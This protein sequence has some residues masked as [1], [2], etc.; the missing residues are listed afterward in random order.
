MINACTDSHWGGWGDP[1]VTFFRVFVLL[2]DVFE[3]GR[4]VSL[5]AWLQCMTAVALVRRVSRKSA[6]LPTPR[7]TCFFEPGNGVYEIT[8]E[9]RRIDDDPLAN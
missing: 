3:Q 6:H 1:H 7:A 2:F 9:Q 4:A 5:L 8:T